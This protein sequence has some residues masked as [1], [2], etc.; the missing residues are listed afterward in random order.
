MGSNDNKTGENTKTRIEWLDVVKGIAIVIVVMGHAAEL[1]WRLRQLI[2]LVHMPVF[3]MTSGMV[4][5]T[6]AAKYDLKRLI[7]PYIIT[8]AFIFVFREIAILRGY[9]Y[10]YESRSQLIRAILYGSGA[11]HNNNVM[12]GELWY[13]LAL[14]WSKRIL[15]SATLLDTERLRAGLILSFCA[16][17]LYLSMH[18]IWLPLSVDVAFVSCVFVYAGAVLRKNIALLLEPRFLWGAA[19]AFG[20]DIYCGY[21]ELAARNYTPWVLAIPGAI[22]GSILLMRFSM[23]VCKVTMLKRVFQY[24]GK[25][26]L[27]FLCIH[28]LDWRLPIPRPGINLISA[29]YNT[30]YY[31]FGDFVTRFVFDL[32]ATI[33]IS[34]FIGLCKRM[35]TR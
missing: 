8:A 14:F 6:K 18:D 35:K 7:V 31:W 3:F 16:T 13:L 24:F 21:C 9:Y 30:P 32:L 28:S 19:I 10:C 22:A 23:E 29:L 20:A 4:Y 11:S 33:V 2:F 27:L 12:I 25:H 17:G 1:P 5:K 34:E 15:D 26:T